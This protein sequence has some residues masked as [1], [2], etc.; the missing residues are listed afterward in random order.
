MITD[1]ILNIIKITDGIRFLFKNGLC[2]TKSQ[3]CDIC[4]AYAMAA[5]ENMTDVGIEISF[6]GNYV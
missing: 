5:Q 2:L 6:Y 1:W 4:K 3:D